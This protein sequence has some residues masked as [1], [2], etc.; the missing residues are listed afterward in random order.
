VS[1]DGRT[2]SEFVVER[3]GTAVK[4]NDNSGHPY[5]TDLSEADKKALIEYL[6]TL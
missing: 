5:G 1:D 6:K 4:G 2:L 3:D